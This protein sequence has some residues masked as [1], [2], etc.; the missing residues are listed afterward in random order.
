M[1]QKNYIGTNRKKRQRQKNTID[2]KSFLKSANNWI[3][4]GPSI[5][6]NAK[7]SR[8][9]SSIL[10]AKALQGLQAMNNKANCQR[11][12]FTTFALRANRYDLARTPLS[13]PPELAELLDRSVPKRPP[14][15]KVTSHWLHD[16]SRIV[17]IK[18]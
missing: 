16:Q 18:S 10:G 2:P 17:A 12:F 14:L 1:A 3:K 13:H 9:L 6:N 15:R 7:F 8:K 4:N 11:C 5:V